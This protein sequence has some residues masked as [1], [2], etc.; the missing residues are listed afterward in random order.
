MFLTFLNMEDYR[1]YDVDSPSVMFA[2]HMCYVFIVA[3]LIFNIL[4]AMIT[5]AVDTV[6]ENREIEMKLSQLD[7][8]RELEHN[9]SSIPLVGRLCNRMWKF[10]ARFHFTEEQGRF[11]V[12]EIVSGNRLRSDHVISRTKRVRYQEFQMSSYST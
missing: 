11:C 5:A 9:L 10:M 6:E 12:V 2:T 8:I 7:S 1:K 3:L 4:V